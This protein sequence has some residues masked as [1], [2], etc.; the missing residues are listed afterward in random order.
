MFTLC[1]M[2]KTIRFAIL[3]GWFLLLVLPLVS[4]YADTADPDSVSIDALYVN[5]HLIETGD[6]LFYLLYDIS[7]GTPPSDPIDETF[8][9]RLLD[10]DQS[11]ELGSV[12]AYEGVSPSNGYGKGV[13]SFY[14]PA[15]TAPAWGQAYFVRIAGKPSAFDDPYSQDF[16]IGSASYTDQTTQDGNRDEAYSQIIYMAQQLEID[17][18]TVTLLAE[19]DIGTVLASQGET[20]F[21]NAIPGLQAMM[22]PLFDIQLQ[23]PSWTGRTWT[24]TQ[25]SEYESRFAGTWVNTAISGTG[26]LFSVDTNLIASIPILIA[27][28]ILL[29]LSARETNQ[30]Y[31]GLL[32][33]VLVIM[34]GG[35]LG[36]TPMAII[37]ILT[38]LCVIYM[39]KEI[40]G[41]LMG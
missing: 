15:S 32:N 13:A 40:A 9:F 1:E 17:W 3:L 18:A 25:Q 12:E 34:I 8:I 31:S 14:F 10:T 33:C 5:R 23:D 19:G 36:W 20:Y 7:Y 30:V 11:T 37:G 38:I 21:R 41:K 4:V 35:A 6:V 28:G 2:K 16:I 39:G 29:Y 26:S 24:T 27:C 22:P